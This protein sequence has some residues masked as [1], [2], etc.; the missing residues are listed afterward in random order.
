MISVAFVGFIPKAI[1][2]SGRHSISCQPLA[3]A[4]GAVNLDLHC[5]VGPE[6]DT[7]S[8]LISWLII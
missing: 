7:E 3:G 6:P 8:Q 4:V 5:L 2:S 1:S